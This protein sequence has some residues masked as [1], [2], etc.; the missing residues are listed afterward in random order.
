MDSTTR[1]LVA[2]ASSVAAHCQPCFRY[3]LDKARKLG[4]S[5][6]DMQSAIELAERISTMGDQRMAEF[7]EQVMKDIQTEVT[8]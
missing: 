3:H 7:V 8:R 1:E 5:E 2:L 6:A 4:I